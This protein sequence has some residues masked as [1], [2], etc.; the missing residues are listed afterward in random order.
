VNFK[1]RAGVASG[2]VIAN[3]R[4]SPYLE[5]PDPESFAWDT[6]KP[7]NGKTAEAITVVVPVY[8][9]IFE[10][11]HC[12]YS[13]LCAKSRLDVRLIVIDDSSPEPDVFEQLAVLANEHG[14]FQLWRNDENRGFVYSANRGLFAAD[15]DVILL[16]SDTIVSDFWV[17]KLVGVAKSDEAI[18]SVSPMTN[19]ATI[20]SYPYPNRENGL[21]DNLT[22]AQID[23]LFTENAKSLKPVEVP[24]NVGYCM[25]IKQ[26]AL[27]AVGGFDEALFGVGYGEECDWCMRATYLGYK[28]AVAID[29]YVYHHG[30]VSFSVK[31]PQRQALAGQALAIRHPEYWP[32][33]A[34]FCNEDS[35]F[36]A[37]RNVDI[38]RLKHHLSKYKGVVLHVLHSLGGG[39][40]VYARDVAR[41]L[42]GYGFESV[43]ARPDHV[44]RLAVSAYSASDMPN[45]VFNCAD[46][47]DL[48]NK[49]I[50]EINLSRMHFHNIIGLSPEATKCIANINIPQT[51][52]LHDYVAICPQ[53][54]LL[55]QRLQYCGVPPARRCNACLR[56][57][58]PPVP[59]DSISAWRREWHAT[60]KKAD[61]VIAPSYFAKDAVTKVFPDVPVAVVP[62]YEERR[63]ETYADGEPSDSTIRKIAVVGN[64]SHHKGRDIIYLC[65]RDSYARHLPLQFVVFGSIDLEEN[66]FGGKLR[67]MGTYERENLGDH[68]F[69]TK[70]RI[71]F[72]PSIWPE[73]FSYVLSEFLAFGLH[74]V[75][76]NLGAQAERLATAGIGTILDV[77]LSAAVINDYLLTI[78]IL[79]PAIPEA[80]GRAERD[81][82]RR[83]YFID[84]YGE[85]FFDSVPRDPP[86]SSNGFAMASTGGLLPK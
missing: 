33:V 61:R 69:R 43:F 86:K 17:D 15:G 29:T 56:E 10:T 78:P 68:L 81:R 74:P 53:L 34:R 26:D 27:Q 63:T 11:L 66:Q 46:D 24:V 67:K 73:T 77:G 25:L 48:V 19:N 2:T 36:R 14:L 12:L 58:R 60:L 3:E 40:E 32:L 51:L 52:T 79:R 83:K 72:L 8:G 37:R 35:L 7:L 71:G 44:G 85:G 1:E 65:A 55:D 31:A 50:K 22:H 76:F 4:R 70:C 57:R 38:K 47:T 62:H 54:N 64:L 75:V 82:M 20:L 41:M 23:D 21:V 49:L 13:L 84:I 16:N 9:A 42:L 45:L 5:L 30:V 6:L 59:A 39:T 28:H 18:A 80:Y